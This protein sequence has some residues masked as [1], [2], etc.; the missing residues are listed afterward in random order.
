MS[1]HTTTSTSWGSIRVSHTDD[2]QLVESACKL[3]GM[4]TMQ[5]IASDANPFEAAKPDH[6]VGC[7]FHPDYTP[8]PAQR[9]PRYQHVPRV[10]APVEEPPILEMTR[11]QAVIWA[12]G[13]ATVLTVAHLLVT[14]WLH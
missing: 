12:L 10:A 3:C 14:W 11:Q 13:G 9:G 1:S 7:R 4:T 2:G 8:P 6:A 5:A